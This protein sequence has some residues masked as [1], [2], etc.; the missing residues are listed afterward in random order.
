ML[1]KFLKKIIRRFLLFFNL[2]VSRIK[3]PYH[4]DMDEEFIKIYEECERFTT[5]PIERMFVLYKFV[6]H[7]VKNKIPGD[8]VECGVWQGGSCMLMAKTLLLLGD[9]QRKIY[10]YDTFDGYSE[11]TSK[12]IEIIS[13]TYKFLL[14]KYTT[15]VRITNRKKALLNKSLTEFGNRGLNRGPY[16]PIINTITA[17]TYGPFKR[18]FNIF[19]FDPREPVTFFKSLFMEFIYY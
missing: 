9:T 17:Y 4:Q 1:K 2:E 10:L 18:F 12:D 11:P 6:K 14:L 5:T 8:F 3:S 16:I 7:I 13:A 19:S 15:R